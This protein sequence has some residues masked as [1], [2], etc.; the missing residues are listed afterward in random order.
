MA[1]RLKEAS[2]TRLSM[3]VKF[4]KSAYQKPPV[5]G[6]KSILLLIATGRAQP[7]ETAGQALLAGVK[8]GIKMHFTR[9]VA[10][11]S[12]HPHLISCPA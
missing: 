8:Q 10:R 12:F 9:A 1:I 4:S 6:S 5:K 7:A 3:V 2:N 11:P